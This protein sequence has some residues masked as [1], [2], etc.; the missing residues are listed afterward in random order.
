MSKIDN[1]KAFCKDNKSAIFMGISLITE[2]AC[3]VTACIST[4]KATEVIEEHNERIEDISNNVTDEEESTELT[5]KAYG[6]TIWNMTKLYAG[7]VILYAASVTF[8]LLA[9]KDEKDK[10]KKAVALLTEASAALV[11]LRTKFT[12]YRNGVIEKYGAQADYDLFNGRKEIVTEEEVV[13]PKTGKKTK[14]KK[15]EV[16]YE[17]RDFDIY[18]REWSMYTSDEWDKDPVKNMITFKCVNSAMKRVEDG[19]GYVSVIDGY[20]HFGI[21]TTVGKDQ[22][23]PYIPS[24]IGWISDT[25][26]NLLPDEWDYNGR[27]YVK[28]EYTSKIDWGISEE[29]LAETKYCIDNSCHDESYILRPNCYETRD[30][31]EFASRYIP[32]KKRTELGLDRKTLEEYDHKHYI[33]I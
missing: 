11:A 13:D 5:R 27:H 9:Y 33:D 28:S 18:A 29:R 16:I 23:N 3:I 7:P 19:A 6:N 30:I 25:I 15:V 20:Q 10:R 32:K 21:D 14:K 24:T 31:L 22:M 12:N 2:L 26:W 4:V 1:V 17:D 8:G